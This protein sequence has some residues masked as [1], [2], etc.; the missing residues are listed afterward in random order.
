MF[1]GRSEQISVLDAELGRVGRSTGRFL[2]TTGRRRV[3]KSRLVQHWLDSKDVPYVYYQAPR[4][5]TEAAIAELNEAIGKSTLPEADLVSAGLSFT[6]WTAALTWIAERADATRP[7]VVVVD[8]LPYLFDAN[9]SLD[10]ELQHVWDRVLEHKPVLL[11]I[12][13][14]DVAMMERL[15]DHDNPLFGRPTKELRIPPLS[16]AEIQDL[17]GLD[18]VEALDAY[19]VIGGFPS[20]AAEWRQ[21]ESRTAFLARM[22]EDSNSPLLVN[23]QRIMQAEFRKE[24]QAQE[25]LEAIGSGERT[26]AGLRQRLDLQPTSLTRSLD[27][28]IG[29]KKVVYRAIPHSAPVTKNVTRYFVLDPH[30]RF[31]LKFL[32]S[33]I[34]EVDRGRG[35]LVGSAIEAEWTDYRGHAIEPIIRDS[36][37]RLLPDERFAAARYIGG[38]FTRSNDVEVDLVGLAKPPGKSRKVEFVGSIKWRET[39]LFDFHD[40]KKLHAIA[41]QV[42]GYAKGPLIGVS[43]AGFDAMSGVVQIGADDIVNAWR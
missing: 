30:L 5:A 25:V 23:A 9:P 13:G 14:S 16:P 31:W 21:A 36:L 34:E 39:G 24:A 4:K 7:S 20:L 18:P 29:V 28:L 12:I 38:Y 40:V 19:V 17:L 3:G 6:T 32:A 43:R 8:E 26:F 2:W 33:G 37:E 10:A 42:P 1:V 35:D 11:V 22:L 15:I 27:T 41:Q